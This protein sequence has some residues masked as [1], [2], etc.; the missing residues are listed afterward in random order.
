MGAAIAS[1][2]YLLGPRDLTALVLRLPDAAPFTVLGN[3]TTGPIEVNGNPLTTPWA[4][5]NI[6][7]V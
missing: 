1:S 2:N 3:I 6:I 5:L 4:P 7:A